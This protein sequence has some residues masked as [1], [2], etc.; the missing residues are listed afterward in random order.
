LGG[1]TL[2][3]A[4]LS[5]TAFRLFADQA[6]API[7]KAVSPTKMDPSTV[8]GA[9]AC[10]ECHKPVI[11]AWQKTKHATFF[12][13]LPQNP[14]AKNY[15]TALGIP[16]AEITGNSV[17]ATCHGMRAE[18]TA[19]KSVTGVSCESCHGPAGGTDGWLNAHGSYGA[20]GV[21]REQETP[22]HR[23]KRFETC[24]KA[25]MVRPE[26][27]YEIARN[28][29][30]CHLMARHGDVVNKSGGHPAGT[31]NFEL[32]SYTHGEVDHNLFID[33]MKNA[34][35]PS[36]WMAR[37]KKTPAERNRVLYIAGKL[38]GMEVAV[39]NL[40]DATKETAFSQAMAG[41]ARGFH[42]DL[43]DIT[44][45]ATLPEINDLLKE[46][47]KIKFKLRANHK[48]VLVPFA[49]RVAQVGLEFV[50]NHDGSKLDG[51]DQNGLIPTNVFGKRYN[52]EA[53]K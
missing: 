13:Q 15:A 30:D 22:E 3:L 11:E 40:A 52:P 43:S 28:C 2:L 26:R 44:S 16:V 27:V 37:Y 32:V 36:L 39:R 42:D 18:A 1:A 23:A 9:Q 14:D 6:T 5:S 33:P 53:G 49:D 48:D 47:R 8:M 41:H 12:P 20:K 50:K 24:D 10:L 38:A 51:L 34:L 29:V 17:C 31:S 25:G 35:A 19:T 4:L 21:T 46:Y 45:S 7:D